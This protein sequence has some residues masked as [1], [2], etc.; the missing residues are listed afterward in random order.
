MSNASSNASLPHQFYQHWTSVSDSIRAA[1]IQELTDI[2]TL[3]QSETDFESF[4]FSRHDFDAYINDLYHNL[5]HEP[6]TPV[7]LAHT[8][9]TENQLVKPETLSTTQAEENTSSPVLSSLSMN[10]LADTLKQG[11]AIE[12]SQ[13]VPQL[14]KENEDL[15]HELGVHIDDY[16][17]DQMTQMSEDLKSWLRSEMSRQLS[18][19]Q[20]LEPSEN[21]N[22]KK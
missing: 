21:D 16:L 19:N 6:A 18:E 7:N 2:N 5:H 1:I 14:T 20:T 3:L 10:P 9:T 8:A 13:S 17:S 12:R 11:A 15:I 4:A 22:N